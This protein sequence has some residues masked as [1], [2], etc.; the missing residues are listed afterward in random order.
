[1]TANPTARLTAD[2]VKAVLD[3][4][5]HLGW[6]YATSRFGSATP[7][8]VAAMDEA[9]VD[10]ANAL[11]LTVEELF[12]WTNAKPGRWYVDRVVGCWEDPYEAI[13][14][15]LRSRAQVNGLR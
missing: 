3:H 2:D 5:D 7:E 12:V 8:Q 10:R 4:P 11:G 6:G 13:G 14:A 9:L 15:Q 1:M